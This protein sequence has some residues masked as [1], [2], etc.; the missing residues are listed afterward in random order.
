MTATDVSARPARPDAIKAVP[1][2]HPGRWVAVLVIAVLAA[3]LVHAIVTNP[4]FNWSEQWK[5]AFSDGIR[6]GVV[7]TIWLTIVSMLIGVVLGVVLAVMRLSENPIL[8]TAGWI[9][10]WVFRGTPVLVQI[11]F[12]A[13]LGALYPRLG[14][15]IP[16]GPEFTDRRPSAL[17]AG[18]PPAWLASA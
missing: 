8:R 4:R 13:G 12:W 3:M 1:V 2:R 11:L 9:Y 10:I 5:Y 18:S 17:T 15:G 6:Q 7:A 16:F 14:I